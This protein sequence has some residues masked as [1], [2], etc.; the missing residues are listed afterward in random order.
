MIRTKQNIFQI[1]YCWHLLAV[2]QI[3]FPPEPYFKMTREESEDTKMKNLYVLLDRCLQELEKGKDLNTVLAEC[4]KQV[5][6][7]IRPLLELSQKL[8]SLSVNAPSIEII[9]RVRL[10]LLNAFTEAKDWRRGETRN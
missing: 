5:E 3:R 6:S 8:R 2:M 10:R 7:Q 4:P 1:R 9:R